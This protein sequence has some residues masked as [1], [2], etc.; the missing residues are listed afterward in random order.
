MTTF[1]PDCKHVSINLENCQWLYKQY[2]GKTLDLTEGFPKDFTIDYRILG[3]SD[4]WP[5]WSRYDDSRIDYDVTIVDSNGSKV[6]HLS[7]NLP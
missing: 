7:N 5:R 6:Q 2:G 3:R 4:E 1:A